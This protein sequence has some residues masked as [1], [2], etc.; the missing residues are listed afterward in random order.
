MSLRDWDVLHL[1]HNCKKGW[2][3]KGSCYRKDYSWEERITDIEL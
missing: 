2:I 3:V 1:A